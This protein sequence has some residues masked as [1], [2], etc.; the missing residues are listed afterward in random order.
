M[1]TCIIRSKTSCG[2]LTSLSFIGPL[3]SPALIGYVPHPVEHAPQLLV[4]LSDKN[5]KYVARS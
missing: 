3:N 2:A 1:T 5:Y 4:P